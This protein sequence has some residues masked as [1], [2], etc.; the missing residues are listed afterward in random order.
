MA[1]KVIYTHYIESLFPLE[2]PVRDLIKSPKERGISIKKR[3]AKMLI[4]EIL[5]RFNT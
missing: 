2:P 1:K 3:S 5:N 4:L